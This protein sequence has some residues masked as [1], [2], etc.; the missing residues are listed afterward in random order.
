MNGKNFSISGSAS[1]RCG[2]SFFNR[3]YGCVR[4]FF[5]GKKIPY[6]FA[7]FGTGIQKDRASIT[8]S[9]RVVL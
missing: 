6:R 9:K 5:A 2:I 4:T 1:S 3:L 7:F 8:S